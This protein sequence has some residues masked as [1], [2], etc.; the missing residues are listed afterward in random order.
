MGIKTAI[1]YIPGTLDAGVLAWYFPGKA[2]PISLWLH[3]QMLN[4][5]VSR[6]KSLSECPSKSPNLPNL[7]PGAW[8]HPLKVFMVLH[9]YCT[10]ATRHILSQAH[11]ALRCAAPGCMR[12]QTPACTGLQPRLL[13]C[14]CALCAAERMN[15]AMSDSMHASDSHA[16]PPC[17]P[18]TTA[19]T[20]P[21]ITASASAGSRTQ[22]RLSSKTSKWQGRRQQQRHQRENLNE[23]TLRVPESA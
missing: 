22:C 23:C 10:Y 12:N 14:C 20:T 19:F 5:S 4:T 6:T 8:A 15:T 17:K 9:T 16:G 13:L 3:R 2:V 11:P 7:P 18:A 21:A 1:Q